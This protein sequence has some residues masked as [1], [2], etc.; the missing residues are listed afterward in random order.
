MKLFN[1]FKEFAV[2]GNMIDMAIGIIIGAAFSKVVDVLV[3]KVLMPPLSLFSNNESLA[4]K[5][6][7]LRKVSL[8]DSGSI[9]DSL[10]SDSNEN[11]MFHDIL[12]LYHLI[13]FSNGLLSS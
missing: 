13:C 4:K 8:S 6:L 9:Y 3:K 10:S 5:K 11:N 2:K 1:E 12:H 7:I